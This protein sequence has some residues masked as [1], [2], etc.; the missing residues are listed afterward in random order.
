ML[1]Q[2][3]TGAAQYR[4][5]L[6]APETVDL[7]MRAHFDWFRVGWTIPFKGLARDIA[8]GELDLMHSK[9]GKIVMPDDHAHLSPVDRGPGPGNR[10]P[11]RL[12]FPPIWTL[13]PRAKASRPF[14]QAW[15]GLAAVSSLAPALRSSKRPSAKT[16]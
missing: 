16:P 7:E 2:G 6:V 1:N 12:L 5:A 15:A 14:G 8:E 11:G 13:P 9:E 3:P 10:H 4:L